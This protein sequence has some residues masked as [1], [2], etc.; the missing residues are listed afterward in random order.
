MKKTIK[1]LLATLVLLVATSCTSIIGDGNWRYINQSAQANTTGDTA[2]IH[3]SASS[4]TGSPNLLM[5]ATIRNRTMPVSA[6][7]GYYQ[8]VFVFSQVVICSDG[9]TSG[10][11][12]LGWIVNNPDLF[13]EVDGRCWGSPDGNCVVS[14]GLVGQTNGVRVLL[15]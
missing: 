10:T 13:V 8:A 4:C 3:G 1:L 2:D 5:Q 11:S 9:V 15:A 14:V 12:Y 7:Q 6:E